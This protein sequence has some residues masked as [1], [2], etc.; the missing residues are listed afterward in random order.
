MLP[1]FPALL[2]LLV[3]SGGSDLSYSPPPPWKLPAPSRPSPPPP[4]AGPPQR[5]HGADTLTSSTPEIKVRSEVL[6]DAADHLPRPSGGH[7]DASP[8]GSSGAVAGEGPLA[9]HPS[10]MTPHQP[11]YQSPAAELSTRSRAGP[12]PSG[13]VNTWVIRAA[14]RAEPRHANHRLA[15]LKP[16][17]NDARGC[18]PRDAPEHASYFNTDTPG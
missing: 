5:G 6:S 2:L 16:S 17:I 3:S 4:P 7:R 10:R 9:L 13:D 18:R 14:S 12:S 8:A 15:P 1:H 11:A